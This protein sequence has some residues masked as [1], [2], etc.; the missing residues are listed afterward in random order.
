MQAVSGLVSDAKLSGR[1]D[2]W[3]AYFVQYLALLNDFC[4]SL[5]IALFKSSG[6]G[7]SEECEEALQGFAVYDASNPATN[8]L[9]AVEMQKMARV[10]CADRSII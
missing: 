8:K 2:V 10:F 1:Y 3:L 4:S 7:L 9:I 5:A 6:A